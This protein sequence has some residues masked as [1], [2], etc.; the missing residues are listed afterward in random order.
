MSDI[1]SSF[2]R[3]TRE[4]K[5]Q[6]SCSAT[7]RLT[8]MMTVNTQLFKLKKWQNVAYIAERPLEKLIL[9]VLFCKD[10]LLAYDMCFLFIEILCPFSNRV[11]S[12]KQTTPQ[13][14]IKTKPVYHP[15]YF[16]NIP[17]HPLV[18]G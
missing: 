18:M 2:K 11:Q 3:T 1:Y 6:Q 15:I 17:G 13:R 10:S 8:C 5:H 12:R 9:F 14:E 4:F 7:K 16:T